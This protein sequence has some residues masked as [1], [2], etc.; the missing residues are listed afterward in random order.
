MTWKTKLEIQVG[1]LNEN[2]MRMKMKQ[3]LQSS[4]GTKKT[5]S[6]TLA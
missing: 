2:A 6:I 3:V 5:Y 4:N 1:G